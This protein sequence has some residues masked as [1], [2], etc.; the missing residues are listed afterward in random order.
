MTPWAEYE[1]EKM[2]L[3]KQNL[4]PQEYQRALRALAERLGL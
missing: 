1:K 3:H 4:T 2:K